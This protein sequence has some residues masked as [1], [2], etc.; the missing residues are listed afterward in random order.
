MATSPANPAEIQDRSKKHRGKPVQGKDQDRPEES[1]GGGGQ[2]DDAD[3]RAQD[4][5]NK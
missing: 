1:R 3:L 4:S 5:G 2:R